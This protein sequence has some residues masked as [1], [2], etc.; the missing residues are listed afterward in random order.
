MKHFECLKERGIYDI[1][2]V[3]A[4]R[5]L[6][7]LTVDTKRNMY[8]VIK[9]EG[10]LTKSEKEALELLKEEIINK[11]AL[12]KYNGQLTGE[13]K[14]YS[15]AILDMLSKQ[16]GFSY[17]SEKENEETIG[18]CNFIHEYNTGKISEE[19]MNKLVSRESTKGFRR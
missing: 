1:D 17:A 11:I 19:K 12:K 7:S 16:I 18:Y 13:T 2:I 5:D 8:Y 4:D 9:P 6:V 10:N 15:A 3:E 14:V